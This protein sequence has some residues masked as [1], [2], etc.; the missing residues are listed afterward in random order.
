MKRIS[1]LVAACAAITACGVSASSGPEPAA[2]CTAMLS[3]D[4][5]VEPDLAEKGKSVPEYCACYATV[6]G[7]QTDED[8]A[9]ILNVTQVLA[10]LRAER[11]LSLKAAA[12]LVEDADDGQAFGATQDEFRTAGQYI[13]EIREELVRDDGQCAAPSGS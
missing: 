10:D 2:I 13:E 4:A 9:A 12:N 7:E 1:I 6:L 3:G 8:R 11:G 5:E